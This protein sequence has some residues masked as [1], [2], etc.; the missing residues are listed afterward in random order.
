MSEFRG[1]VLRPSTMMRH[2]R[3]SGA[4]TTPVVTSATGSTSFMSGLT[5]F[6]PGAAIPLHF[7]NC[8]ESV[9]LIDGIAVAEIDGVA[10]DLLPGDTSLI[11]AGVPHRFRNASDDV[12]MTILW[13]YATLD[14]TRTIVA[15]GETRRVDAEPGR[16]SSPDTMG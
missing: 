7:H 12:P 11:P 10:H 1:A 5:H 15:T 14:A 3:G 2:D 16:A 6:A 4:A 13:T 9:C 8:D